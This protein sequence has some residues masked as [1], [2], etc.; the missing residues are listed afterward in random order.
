MHFLAEA[1]M[2]E[3]LPVDSE[4]EREDEY[5]LDHEL[6][7]AVME[8]VD[9][10]D[11]VGVL[12]LIA[13]LHVADLAD[14]TEQIDAAHRRRF[15][16]LVW[17]DIDQ[18]ILVE[19]E[20]GVRDE[21]LSFL[22]PEKLAEAVKDL[23]S[24]DVVYLLEDLEEDTQ[25]Q[26]LEAMEPADRAA[27]TKSLAYPEDTA[28]RLMQSQVVKAPPF[29]TVGQMIDYLRASEDLPEDFYDIII[30]DPAAKPIGTVPLSVLLGS[31][32]PVTLESLMADDFRTIGVE[33]PQEDVA[34]AFNQYH[35]VSAPVV[36]ETGR[37]VGVITIDDAMEVLEDEAE[38][39]IMRLGGVG[40]EEISDKVW[41]IAR[42][43]FPWLAVNLVTAI[44]ASLVIGMFEA[45]IAEIV[46]LA[47]LMP[48]VASMGGNAGTQ[49][50]TVAVRA[51]ATRDLTPTNATRVIGRE[52]AVG[53]INGLGF[54]AIMGVVAWV[55]FDQPMI[56]AVI[57]AAMVVN[58]AAAALA[59][60]LVPIVLDKVGADPAL[61]SGTFVTTVT[62]VVGFF[63]F[64]GLAAAVLL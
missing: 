48:I 34:Y 59:G 31:R 50:L 61:A 23:D 10:G 54:A 64:L 8:S 45:T 12:A 26:V 47:I 13:D 42:R 29:W 17:A 51:L 18:E 55:W 20:E 16:E 53:L 25:R 41:E 37:L 9:A 52:V 40:D 15:I 21:I 60:I 14:L 38:E 39:D 1:S 19:V 57:A 35:L 30:V 62:D 24:D 33:E 36:D 6:A 2:N 27:V 44:M 28:G 58:L 4:D 46:A 5:E 7:A 63:V 56:G 3:G 49:T 43:R 11:R 32:R 22:A